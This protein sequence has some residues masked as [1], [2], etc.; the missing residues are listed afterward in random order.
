MLTSSAN[1]Y[2]RPE[3]LSPIQGNTIELDAKKSPLALLA[4]TCS[5]IGSD[6]PQKGEA[7][8]KDS[9]S[10]P[11]AKSPSSVESSDESTAIKIASFR[12]Y[13]KK[14][15]DGDEERSSPCRKT[16]TRLSPPSQGSPTVNGCHTPH[17]NRSSSRGSDSGRPA[18]SSSLTRNH[19]D[20]PSYS[21]SSSS[22]SV[23]TSSPLSAMPKLGCFSS[24]L[25]LGSLSG[26]SELCKD[27]LAAYKLSPG[28]YPALG[29]GFDPL[30]AAGF[31]A[32]TAKVSTAST[33]AVTG[34]HSSSSFTTALSSPYITWTRVKTTGGSET[35]IPVC[36][37]PYCA[38]CQVNTHAAQVVNGSCPPGCSQCSQINTYSK[39]LSAALPSVLHSLPASALSSLYGHPSLLGGAV[40]SHQNVCNWISGDSYCGKR[41]NSAEELLQHLRSH[42]SSAVD[43]SAATLASLHHALHPPHPLLAGHLPRGYPT[44]PLS[45]LSASARYHPYA[46]K[47]SLTH[48]PP[49]AHLPPASALS[50][51]SFSALAP[52]PLSAYYS[53]Y[54]IYARSLGAT[55]GLHP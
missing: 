37:D 8:P 32:L 53:P 39:N 4:A 27:P 51:A 28:L 46:A 52:H 45:P 16:P 54:S 20:T 1:Q 10:S 31:A 6:G 49:S 5:Q 33:T 17:H 7:K 24:S 29:L 21:S 25:G 3:Y 38:G 26:L 48:L 41:F 40:S 14:K 13:E 11:V 44:P 19:N 23:R 18:S 50:V 9:K 2:L 22:T 34:S 30:G 43:A 36:R 35:V 12:P 15:E 47:P 55:A 42:T